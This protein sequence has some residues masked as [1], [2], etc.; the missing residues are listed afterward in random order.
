MF[1]KNWLYFSDGEWPE[2]MFMLVVMKLDILTGINWTLVTQFNSWGVNK[3]KDNSSSLIVSNIIQFS[4]AVLPMGS[5]ASILATRD[6]DA[7]EQEQTDTPM[8]EKYDHMLHGSS[9]KRRWVT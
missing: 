4:I 5:D 7:D 3:K 1:S 9:R 2:L 6:P 8:Y